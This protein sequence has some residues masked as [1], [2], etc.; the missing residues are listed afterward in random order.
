MN[1]INVIYS[2]ILVIVLLFASL[3]IGFR[4]DSNKAPGEDV[5]VNKPMVF[6]ALKDVK[7]NDS[8][9]SPKLDLW[10]DITVNDIFN[11]FEGRYDAESRRDLSE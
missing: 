10:S 11:K 1:K 7:V 9:W 2:T 6:P 5:A 3:F 4:I 8:F